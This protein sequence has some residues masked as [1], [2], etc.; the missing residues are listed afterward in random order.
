MSRRH[1]SSDVLIVGGGPAGL[2]AACAAAQDGR[3]VTIVDDNPS[4]GGQV[5]RGE[6]GRARSPEAAEWFAAI[7]RA[8]VPVVRGARV[9]DRPE[10]GLLLAETFDGVYELSYGKL[11]LA[12]GARERFLPFPG[13]TLPNVMGAGGLQAFVKSGLS[14]RGE[15][16][17]VAG[18]GPLLLA[19]AAYLR[20][21]GADIRLIAEQA[22][23]H[24]LARFGVALLRHPGKAAQALRLRGSLSGVPYRAG[25]WPI[26]AEGREKISRVTL[27]Q[28]RRTWSEPCDYL[29]C[30]FHLVPNS[31][32]ALL[33]GCA[34]RNGRGPRQM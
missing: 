23:W 25:C 34:V 22:P 18:S 9:F 20:Q 4:P 27:R 32:L 7:Q 6:S 26:A 14:I 1:H 29:A 12:T 17:V 33:L 31:E 5:W 2:A 15:R 11:I 10:E 19:V 28:G 3:R 8:S 21:H 24:R 30:G 16:V 13:W